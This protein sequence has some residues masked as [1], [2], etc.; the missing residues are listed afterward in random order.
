MEEEEE[1]VDDDEN[2]YSYF[3]AHLAHIMRYRNL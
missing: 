1:E 2:C 3:Y